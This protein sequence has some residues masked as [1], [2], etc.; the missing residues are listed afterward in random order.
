VTTVKQLLTLR[1]QSYMAGVMCSSLE[2]KWGLHKKA[3][4]WP[5]PV[6]GGGHFE[7]RTDMRWQIVKMVWMCTSGIRKSGHLDVK[8]YH[9]RTFCVSSQVFHSSLV[10]NSCLPIHMTH[11]NYSSMLF[12]YAIRC[13]LSVTV[14]HPGRPESS[15]TFLVL[16][17]IYRLSTK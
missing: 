12:W 16:D 10:N 17:Y 3:S 14:S 6:P 11:D 13:S 5:L 7:Y 8:W 4:K 2:F 15:R 1:Y 9:K